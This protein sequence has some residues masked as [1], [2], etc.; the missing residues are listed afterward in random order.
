[1][2]FTDLQECKKNL[3]EGKLWLCSERLAQAI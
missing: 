2:V 1:M 3:K